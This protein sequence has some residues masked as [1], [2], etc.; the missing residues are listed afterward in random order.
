MSQNYFIFCKEPMLA[1][2]KQQKFLNPKAIYFI[3]DTVLE[4]EELQIWQ[5]FCGNLY[6]TYC[7]GNQQN[8]NLNPTNKTFVV[9]D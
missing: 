9:I 4:E 3:C 1:T 2:I 8:V 6:L 5:D 7:P